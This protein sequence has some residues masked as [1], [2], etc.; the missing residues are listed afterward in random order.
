MKPARHK[1]TTLKQI[2]DLIPRNLVAKLAKKHGVDKRSRKFTPWSHVVSLIFA[3]TAHSLSLN[4]I[5]DTLRNHSG[6]LSTVRGAVPPSRNGLSY[7]NRNRD[8]N[9]AEELF[10]ET[11][12][13]FQAQVPEFGMGRKYCGFPRRFKRI[14]NVVDS[15]TISLVANCMDWAK[16]RRRKAAAKCHMRLDLQTFLPRFAV[17]KEASS[18]DAAVARQVCAD[19]QAGEIVTFDKAYVDFDHLFCLTNREVFWVTRAKDNMQY[20]VV[21]ENTKPTGNILRDE[22]IK[23]TVPKSAKDYPDEMRLIEA[24]VEIDGKEQVLT[25]I[26][27]NMQWAPTSICNL[28]KG[29]WGIEVFFKQIKQTLQLADFLG[30]NENAVRWQVWTALLT[31]LLLRFIAH[32]SQWQGTFARLFTAL[33]G[34]LWSRLDV[35]S[36]LKFCGTA[37]GPPRMSAAPYQAYMPGFAL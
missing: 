37:H 22:R 21:S 15:T 9:M 12:K 28:Y 18:S 14:I 1:F 4:D 30:Y 6:D 23:L 13:T 3:Q 10:W 35:D 24:I 26:S 17:V 19:I 27:N 20:D 31:Y 2:C 34:V 32:R 5:S 11:L 8:A 33:R 16:H 25:F 7:A 29:R 36:M